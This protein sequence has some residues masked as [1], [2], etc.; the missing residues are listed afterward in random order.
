MS[1][2]NKTVLVVGRGSGIARAT[3]TALLAAGAKVVAAGRDQEVL[4]AAY[5]GTAVETATVDLNDEASIAALAESIEV[6]HVVST[7]SARARGLVAELTP[8]AMLG[9]FQTKVI[10]PILLAKHFAP[11]LPTDGSFVFF[12]GHSARKSHPGM[13]AVGATNAAVDAVA[14]SLAVELAPLRVNAVSPGTIDTGAYDGLGEAAKAELFA[15]RVAENPVG[16]LGTAEDVAGAVIFA[17]TSTFVTG[18]SVAVDGGE[19]I[20]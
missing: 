4:A 6:D 1:L 10:G 8:A 13:L 5:K 14:R 7:A 15:H 11:R 18:T 9:S 20:V 2:E 17:L 12:S 16:R 3:V 19:P